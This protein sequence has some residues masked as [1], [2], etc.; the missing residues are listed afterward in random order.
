MASIAAIRVLIL[1]DPPLNWRSNISFCL[2]KRAAG[3]YLRAAPG[4]SPTEKDTCSGLETS[5]F[6]L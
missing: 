2:K 4:N 1:C 6:D 3:T 5:Y